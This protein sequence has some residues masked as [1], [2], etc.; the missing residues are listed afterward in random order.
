MSFDRGRTPSG[1]TGLVDLTGSPQ[2]TL[3]I[4]SWKRVLTIPT[5]PRS[6]R[7]QPR[8]ESFRQLNVGS[9]I[10]LRGNATGGPSVV[11]GYPCP[12]IIENSIDS[13]TVQFDTGKTITF[14]GVVTEY[15][16]ELNEKRADNWDVGITIKLT[17]RPVYV[18]FGNTQ[19]TAAAQTPA[20]AQT[21]QSLAKTYDPVGL[22]M[23]AVRRI[24]VGTVADSDAAEVAKAMLYAASGLALTSAPIPTLIPRTGK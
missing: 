4:T 13:V 24:D 7:G 9:Q 20:D 3:Y 2:F 10:A 21:D 15:S 16:E 8:W 1:I 22:L 18:G 5:I 14:T 23:N 6:G 12:V 17:T 19:A 11:N